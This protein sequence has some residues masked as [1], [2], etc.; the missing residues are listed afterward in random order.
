M[1]GGILEYGLFGFENL[2]EIYSRVSKATRYYS[3]LFSEPNKS[4]IWVATVQSGYD[5]R[6]CTGRVG[7]LK[8]RENG[9]YY[10]STF[11]AAIESD[12]DMIFVITWNEWREHS[13]IE[14]S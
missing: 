12:P 4:K 8:E 3:L 13:H 9:M 11:E 10:W 2:N 14:P 6:F 7:L 1:F 5:D